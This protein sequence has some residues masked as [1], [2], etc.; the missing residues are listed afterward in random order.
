MT[1]NYPEPMGGEIRLSKEVQ[2]HRVQ[3]TSL[4]PVPKKTIT[5]PEDVASLLKELEDYDREVGIILYLDSKNRVLGIE[6]ISEGT[7]NAALVHPRETV[8]GAILQNAAGVIFAH[9]H[10]SGIPKPSRE[11]DVLIDKL[12]EAFGFLGIDVIDAIIIGKEG[13]YSYKEAGK[14]FRA[15]LIGGIMESDIKED[16]TCETALRAAMETMNKYCSGGYREIDLGGVSVKVE[17]PGEIMK[18]ME[19]S[20]T[21]EQRVAAVQESSWARNAARGFCAKLFGQ[22]TPECIERVSRKLAEG[23]VSKG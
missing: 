11:D 4:R 23:M 10:P 18:V 7:L 1:I 21:H 9:N 8:K 3:L 20:L 2:T 16:D 22:E 14:S 15:K 12:I 6:K 5:K 19:E 13:T 17:A